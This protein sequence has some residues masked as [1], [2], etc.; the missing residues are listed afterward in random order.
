MSLRVGFREREPGVFVLSPSGRLDTN[1]YH[2][3]ESKVDQIISGTPRAIVFDMADLDYVSSMGVRVIIKAEKAL[4]KTG[5]K[6]MMTNLQP[7]IEKVF[8]IIKALPSFNLFESTEEMDEY[9]DKMQ[10]KTLED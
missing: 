8:E 6:I 7:Q 1:T 4:S 9:L 10:K 2:E 3:L 5:G